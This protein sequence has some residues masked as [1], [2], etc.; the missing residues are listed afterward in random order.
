MKVQVA[1][2]VAVAALSAA[3]QGGPTVPLHTASGV[4]QPFMM[5][6]GTALPPIGYVG[7]CHRSPQE[8]D[9]G[10]Q[11]VEKVRMTP[12]RWAALNAVNSDVNAAVLP[13]T[14]QELYKTAEFWTLPGRAGDC[15]DYVLQK[16]KM[17]ISDGWPASALLV[18]VVRD[19]IG[20]GH[21]VLTVVSDM[22]DLVLDNKTDLIRPWRETPYTYYKRQSRRNASQWVT[23]RPEGP[24]LPRLITTTQTFAD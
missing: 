23:L 8:C 22:G 7:F 6:Y 3:C 14:D 24:G 4:E 10:A 15:E 13:A 12:G 2:V 20:D 18:T 21:A 17:L 19:E 11:R 9:R 1:V 16:R 5:E